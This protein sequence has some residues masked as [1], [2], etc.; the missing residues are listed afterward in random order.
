MALS[1]EEQIQLFFQHPSIQPAIPGVCSVLHLLRRDVLS[2]LGVD[3]SSG[4]QSDSPIIWPGIMGILAGIDLLAKFYA[5]NDDFGGVTDRFKTFVGKYFDMSADDSELV[6]QLRNS[7]L[8]SFGWYSRKKNGAEYRFVVGGGD[9]TG[10]L[11]A[12]PK[13]DV[14]IVNWVRLFADFESAIGRYRGDLENDAD[15][16]TR[17]ASMSSN[18]GSMYIG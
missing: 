15:L 9:P 8:H 6:Y 5:G 4:K 12:N 18:Y 3:L 7:V 1:V 14:Y 11:T 10:P 2:C 16:K 17:F 13:S